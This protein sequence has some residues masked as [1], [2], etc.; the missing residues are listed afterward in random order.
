MNLVINRWNLPIATAS[1]KTLISQL[2]HRKCF[3]LT[4]ITLVT[5]APHCGGSVI[6]LDVIPSASFA[7]GN[8][9]IN[10]L[11]INTGNEPAFSVRIK[12]S[13]ADIFAISD[14][15]T[16][17]QPGERKRV[18]LF[19]PSL[20]HPPGIHTVVI[21]AS[22]TDGNRHPFT[23]LGSTHLVTAN[24]EP[25][26]DAVSAC[27]DPALLKKTTQIKLR[28]TTQHSDPIHVKTILVLP[29]EITCSE[30]EKQLIVMPGQT[31]EVC[32]HIT[33][34]SALN[35]ST[36]SIFAV[37][38]YLH[39]NQHRSFSA[40]APLTITD[41]GPVT[42][43]G[44][45]WLFPFSALCFLLI[46]AISILSKGRKHADSRILKVTGKLLSAAI[47]LAL[48]AYVLSH[49]PL[50]DLI[51]DTMTV[52]GDTPAHNYLA[53]H[54]KEQLVNHGRIAS[55][56]GGWWCGFP[57]FQYYFP[58]PY[59]II[60]ALSFVI[61]FNIAFKLVTILGIVALPASAYLAGR[62]MKLQKPVPVLLAVA[63]IP[64]LFDGSHTMWGVNIYSTLAGMIANS[65]SFPI[66]LLYI[67]CVSRD[68]DDGQFR[69]S[70]VFLLVAMLSSH[71]F[72]SIIAAITISILPFLR[73]KCGIAKALTTIIAET[74]FGLLL[75]AW[76][77]VPLIAK[78]Q[79]SVDF[80][81]NW[82][83]S[84]KDHI[85]PL[86]ICALLAVP[87]T[88]TAAT[89]LSRQNRF[90]ILNWWMFAWSVF[91]FSYGYKI[92][93]IFVNVRLWP[94]IQ[95]SALALCAAGTG[96]IIRRLRAYDFLLILITAL[97]LVYG[98]RTAND[99]RQWAKWNYSG[100]ENKAYSDVFTELVLPLKGTAGRLSNDLH[101][102]NN[103]LGSSRIFECV[104]H[105]IGK[106]ILE[107]GIVN[108]AAGSLFSYYIQGEASKSCAGFPP[109]VKPA[110]FNFDNATTH[111]ELFNVKH[112]IAR[113]EGTKKAL[114]QSDK[115]RLLK[116]CRDWELYEL[117]SHDGSYVFIPAYYPVAVRTDDWKK[118]CLEWIYNID[119]IA[120]PFVIFPE[121]APA[122]DD[123]PFAA[124]IDT[125]QFR[126]FLAKKTLDLPTH[127]QRPT[128]ARRHVVRKEE[129]TDNIIRFTT[130][131]I[132]MPHI[133]KCSYYPNWKVRGADKVYMVTP[134][135]MLVYPTQKEVELY[136]GYTLSDNIGRVLSI[137]GLLSVIFFTVTRI[138]RNRLHRK[139]N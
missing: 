36:Y 67:A 5:F 90:N 54:L 37:V 125:K 26:N 68:A 89:L 127:E 115:W 128:H 55:W 71:F 8:A 129:I 3:I 86:L 14:E 79:Y 111:F 58:L 15:T 60:A 99:I 100:L 53:S 13:I 45:T 29:S 107:G 38:D 131:G 85:P 21:E 16:H 2:M 110:K 80:G 103:L 134:N 117:L 52:G 112:F 105:L 75:M 116:K 102:D 82:N 22:Y 7:N 48:T 119:A 96:W 42:E 122:T 57:M 18:P 123:M 73:P 41:H 76:W 91:L 20:P 56:A 94:F 24:V 95:Y 35:G 10:V 65:L 25:D 33:N 31:N 124:I 17:I 83:V 126:G 108:S 133:I 92:S 11:L 72:T 104:P 51:S 84:I 98:V 64:I 43:F 114:S 32:F 135:F 61:P 93:A 44:K 66:M 59:L 50:P 78:H 137:I 70:T 109:I 6:S 139:N 120:Q 49:F 81:E 69:L 63:V 130:D 87:V 23:A 4:F 138:T 101:Q 62:I 121:D 136:Y 27:L 9:E 97:T 12:A 40:F 113:W 118:T 132:G 74:C 47:L 88:A 1:H 39:N 34:I 77:L 19:L 28:L 106:P 30:P 46:V